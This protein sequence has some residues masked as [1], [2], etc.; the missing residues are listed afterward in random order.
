MPLTV[1]TPQVTPA[2]TKIIVPTLTP[3]V[4]QTLPEEYAVE[5]QVA[6]NGNPVDPKIITTFRGGRGINFI[7]QVEV[8]NNRGDGTT[9]TA[10]KSRPNVGDTLELASSGRDNDRISV[11]V[12]ISNGQKY[13]IFDQ[14][15]AL[16]QRG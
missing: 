9:E 16:K 1:P 2:P 6:S 13:L 7:T 10:N 15:V 8:V 14:A 4:V 5:V 12:T 11:Y 3:G